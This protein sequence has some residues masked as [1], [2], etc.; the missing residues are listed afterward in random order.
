MENDSY[1]IPA[2][3]P[4]GQNYC[5]S[6]YI[7]KSNKRN[8]QW[9]L[10]WE[11]QTAN[12]GWTRLKDVKG[13]YKNIN[14]FIS[15]Y[16]MLTSLYPGSNK[17]WKHN[18]EAMLKAD[19]GI[20][21]LGATQT[22]TT[23]HRS[24]ALSGFMTYHGFSAENCFV[25]AEKIRSKNHMSAFRKYCKRWMTQ[26]HHAF[27][28]VRRWPLRNKSL[29]ARSVLSPCHA[30][31]D[32]PLRQFM[33]SL[34]FH[35]SWVPEQNQLMY[36]RL[37]PMPQPMVRC[38]FAAKS[39]WLSWFCGSHKKGSNKKGTATTISAATCYCYCYCY[40]YYYYYYYY[41]YYYYYYCYY[42]YYYYYY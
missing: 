24:R 32:G 28:Y 31:D 40:Y 22:S 29:Q 30:R 38:A 13:T 5:S 7:N 8:C 2:D 23:N 16:I 39:K 33:K 6:Q 12:D 21:L 36:V 42:Y 19:W 26:W 25:L 37:W 34:I 18:M 27:R 1:I 15:F 20:C 3:L 14:A 9:L 41:C 17:A 10:M 4:T 35:N 11:H